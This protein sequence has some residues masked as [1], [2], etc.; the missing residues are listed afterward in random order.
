MRWVGPEVQ[1]GG[2]ELSRH[3]CRGVGGGFSK[4]THLLLGSF[5]KHKELKNRRLAVAQ[6]RFVPSRPLQPLEVLPG[7]SRR[8]LGQVTPEGLA[9]SAPT[10]VS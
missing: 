6:K 9:S 1:E 10:T 7:S 3:G 8:G 5:Q 4:T 2:P